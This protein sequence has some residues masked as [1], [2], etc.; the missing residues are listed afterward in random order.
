MGNPEAK[1]EAAKP[2]PAGPEKKLITFEQAQAKMTTEE[3]AT[4]EQLKADY[5]K[6]L[7]ICKP[8]LRELSKRREQLLA[9]I[10]AVNINTGIAGAGAIGY[11]LPPTAAWYLG[12]ST[13]F[14]LQTTAQAIMAN[15][16]NS[17]IDDLERFSQQLMTASD[18]FGK[19]FNK[20]KK[21]MREKYSAGQA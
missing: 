7:D 17:N 13:V 16:E 5:I 4:F 2:N 10:I 14:N 8:V 12:I 1:Q 20:Y 6:A 15:I 11:F 3:K 9:D 19:R 21:S 18:D